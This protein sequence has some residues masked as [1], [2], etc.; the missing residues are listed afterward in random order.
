MHAL[1]LLGDSLSVSLLKAHKNNFTVLRDPR[2]DPRLTRTRTRT[3][4]VGY[5]GY[6]PHR[7]HRRRRHHRLHSRVN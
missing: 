5:S 2:L 7:R 4:T 3:H 6:D 1:P